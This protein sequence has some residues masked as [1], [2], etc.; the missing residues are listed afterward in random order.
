MVP[1]LSMVTSLYILIFRLLQFT[2][3]M[4]VGFIFLCVIFDFAL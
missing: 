4:L 3:I 1:V 2:V